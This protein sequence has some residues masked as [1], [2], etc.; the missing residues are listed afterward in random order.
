MEAK[1]LEMQPSQIRASASVVNSQRLFTRE[2]PEV[3][4]RAPSEM[5]A[6]NTREHLPRK[7]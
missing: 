2:R 6:L 7:G 1:Q 4:E 3:D 5:R